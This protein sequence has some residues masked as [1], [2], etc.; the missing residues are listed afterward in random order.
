MRICTAS[1]L[2]KLHA[3]CCTSFGHVAVKK[4]RLSRRARLRAC[5]SAALRWLA[6]LRAH[7]DDLADVVFEAHVE[8]AVSFIQDQVVHSRKIHRRRKTAIGLSCTEVKEPAWRCD[9]DVAAAL[10]FAALVAFG[11]ASEDA[12]GSRLDRRSELLGLPVNLLSE[13]P[14]GSHY[15]HSWLGRRCAAPSGRRRLRPALGDTCYCGEK[16]PARLAT[17]GRCHGDHVTALQADGPALGLNRSRRGVT[18]SQ[19][20]FLKGLA[21]LWASRGEGLEWRRAVAAV[22]RDG[23]LV[24]LSVIHGSQYSDAVLGF[25]LLRGRLNGGGGGGLFGLLANSSRFAL[26]ACL[27]R[28]H[29][30]IRFLLFFLCRLQ[31]LLQGFRVGSLFLE[32]CRELGCFFFGFPRGLGCRLVVGH[33]IAGAASKLGDI[34]GHGSLC[35]S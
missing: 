16:E 27:L 33:R 25:L 22:A 21:E 2:V 10:E 23:D 6:G 3:V 15:E 17:A 7:L 34:C 4:K 20:R 5:G 24:R 12:N 30:G 35:G 26:H 1:W 18:L 31:G 13:F 11:H 9:E 14:C 28:G 19:Q 29:G 8:H 32:L